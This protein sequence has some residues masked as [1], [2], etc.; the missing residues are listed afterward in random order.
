MKE[1][2]SI[3]DLMDIQDLINAPQDFKRLMKESDHQ[4][5]FGF[6]AFCKGNPLTSDNGL[7]VMAMDTNVNKATYV[8]CQI[9][10]EAMKEHDPNFNQKN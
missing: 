2:N 5:I 7:R 8:I 10:L 1:I 3:Q 4:V 6:I 9:L